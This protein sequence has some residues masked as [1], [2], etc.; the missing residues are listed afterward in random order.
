MFNR[1]VFLG[2]RDLCDISNGE[3][4]LLHPARVRATRPQ[5]QEQRPRNLKGHEIN[6]NN[7]DVFIDKQGNVFELVSRY[8][9]D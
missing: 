9:Y 7:N 8:N 5:V 3:D 2:S 4:A 1:D 6:N